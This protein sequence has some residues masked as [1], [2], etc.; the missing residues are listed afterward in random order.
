METLPEVVSTEGTLAIPRSYYTP[1]HARTNKNTTGPARLIRSTP[2]R[3]LCNKKNT[4]S[5]EPLPCDSAAQAA[6]HP[7]I[8]CSESL[9]LPKGLAEIRGLPSLPPTAAAPAAGEGAPR[10][11]RRGSGRWSLRYNINYYTIIYHK[12]ITYYNIL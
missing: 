2:Y 7:L 5:N 8:W 12:L 1:T 6:L 11:P 9:Y 4:P 10:A 3:R